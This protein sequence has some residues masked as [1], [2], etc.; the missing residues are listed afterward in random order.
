[1]QYTSVDVVVICFTFVLFSCLT[2]AMVSGY[3]RGSQLGV[4][5]GHLNFCLDLKN[6]I[7]PCNFSRDFK[8]GPHL[9]PRHV[10]NSSHVK[11]F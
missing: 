8:L 2:D 1:M 3:S 7:N 6:K 5:D 4:R 11:I 9:G 10:M